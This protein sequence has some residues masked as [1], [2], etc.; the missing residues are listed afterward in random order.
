[1]LT[2]VLCVLSF[3]FQLASV[4]RDVRGLVAWFGRLGTPP[5]GGTPPGPAPMTMSDLRTDVAVEFPDRE[6]ILRQV[7]VREGDFV[8]VPK[9]AT[10][11]DR[12]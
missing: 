9:I 6:G 4:D 7:P 10:E 2:V 11:A 8:L 1:M 3:P 5:S 12:H